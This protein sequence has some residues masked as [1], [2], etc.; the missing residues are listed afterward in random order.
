MSLCQGHINNT[1]TCASLTNRLACKNGH[2]LIYTL[3]LSCWLTVPQASLGEALLRVAVSWPGN[4]G[5]IQQEWLVTG[6][7]SLTQLRDRLYCRTD[8]DMKSLGLAKPSGGPD[9]AGN[10]LARACTLLAWNVT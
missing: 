9:A 6:S 10:D 5:R 8:L 7:Q 1:C 3:C 4:P 2:R